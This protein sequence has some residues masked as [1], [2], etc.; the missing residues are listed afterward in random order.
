MVICK[1]FICRQLK[2]CLQKSETKRIRTD[3]KIFFTLSLHRLLTFR[4]N[5]VK[6]LLRLRIVLRRHVVSKPRNARDFPFKY[7][8]SFTKKNNI[9]ITMFIVKLTHLSHLSCLVKPDRYPPNMTSKTL[10]RHLKTIYRYC[11]QRQV[12]IKMLTIWK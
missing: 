1:H 3:C 4:F 9:M 6:H 5:F 8:C 12:V 7:I 11:R 2:I 10:L